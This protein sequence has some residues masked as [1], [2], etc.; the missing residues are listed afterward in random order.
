MR[1]NKRLALPIYRETA[2]TACT[3]RAYTE[4]AHMYAASAVIGSPI[5]SIHSSSSAHLAAWNKTVVG[6]AVS[7]KEVTAHTMWS[8]SSVPVANRHFSANHFVILH[9]TA[10]VQLTPAATVRQN[11]TKEVA[12]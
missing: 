9:L 10:T 6:R 3:D 1:N 2:R 12:R 4:T 8:S 11:R 7:A 5:P